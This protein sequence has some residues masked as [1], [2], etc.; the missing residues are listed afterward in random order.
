MKTIIFCGFIIS[1]LALAIK[2]K[3]IPYGDKIKVLM[4]FTSFI[5]GASIN[6]GYSY[7]GTSILRVPVWFI[8]VVVFGIVNFLYLYKREDRTI[9]LIML[10]IILNLIIWRPYIID[11]V[12][13]YNFIFIYVAI[14]LIYNIISTFKNISLDYILNIII[15]ISIANSTLGIL[16]FFLNKKLLP[17]V[18]NESILFLEETGGAVKR[19]VGF[20]GTNNAAGAFGAILFC[21]SLYMYIKN[22]RLIYLV[23]VILNGVFSVLTLTRI[24]YLAIFI[25]LLIFY[26]FTKN[27]NL[28]QFIKKYFIFILSVVFV[29]VIL[30]LFGDKIY[31]TL[32]LNRGYTA[33]YRITQFEFVINNVIKNNVI[34]GV[35]PGQLNT[36][37]LE[38][39]GLIELDLH[40]QYLNVLAEQGIF[41]F[42]CFVVFNIYILKKALIKHND[43]LTKCL[44]WAIFITSLVC[45]NYNPNQYY[46][47]NNLIYYSLI[48]SLIKLKFNEN[49]THSK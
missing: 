7:N 32:F 30:V 24:G 14:L 11:V 28:K 12:K 4:L 29:I 40:S 25:Q 33:N 46:P 43:N 6:S 23:T 35:G 37:I 36:Y 47:I 21:V 9:T 2:M 49:N 45:F 16:Q 17:G 44:V 1:I 5:V 42:T 48:F 15:G 13:Y 22:K 38:Q 19:I 18:W 41:I 20:A 27:I 10:I 26:L 39:L 8:V 3:I 31:E 34:F